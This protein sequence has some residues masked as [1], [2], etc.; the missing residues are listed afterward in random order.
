MNSHFRQILLGTAVLSLCLLGSSGCARDRADTVSP[1][2]ERGGAGADGNITAPPSLSDGEPDPDKASMT[3]SS[4][5]PGDLAP[6][7]PPK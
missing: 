7:S 4:T 3:E 6:A 5:P 1:G 2:A